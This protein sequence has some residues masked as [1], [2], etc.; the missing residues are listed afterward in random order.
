MNPS[1]A[2]LIYAIGIAGLFFLGR[3]NSLR[4]SKALWI[5]VIWIW[6]VG[7]RPVSAWLGMSP[8]GNVQLDGSPIDAAVFGVLVVA[9]IVVLIS[10][11]KRTRVLLAANWPILIYFFYC[12]ISVIWSYHPDVA[13]KR[14]IKAIGDLAIVLVIVT[15]PQVRDALNRLFS[16]VGFLLFPAS[17]LLIKYYGDLG[18]GYT[19]D[20]ELMNT[21]VTTNKNS[22][23]LI[24]FLISLG[25]LW[26]VRALLADKDAPNRTRRLIAQLTLLTFGIVLLEMAHC[27]TAVT[28]FALGAGLMFLT[29]RRAIRNRP[30]RVYAL[31]LV[32]VLGGGLGMFFG[33]GSVLS[34][35]LGRGEGL[36]GRTEIWTAVIGAAGNPVIGTGFESFWISPNVKEVYRSL[37]GWWAPQGLNEAHNGYLEIYLNLGWIGVLLIALI[38]FSGYRFAT[39]AFQYDPAVASLM[40]TWVATGTFYSVTEAGFRYLSPPWLFLLLAVV[41]STGVISGLYGGQAPNVLASQ[42]GTVSRV[43]ARNQPIPERESVYSARPGLSHFDVIRAKR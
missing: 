11:G 19:P 40:L 43:P 6:I 30:G 38:L 33:G 5:P 8:T 31:C 24:V 10:R 34:E 25:T 20:G 15:E 32:I 16:R 7:S 18:R 23:G 41:T 14:W 36:S 26:N 39:R 17:V 2:S 12:L 29:T 9:A 37:T 28:C 35:S 3:E 21:G 4:T 13:F 27:A 42:G 1:L 22:L